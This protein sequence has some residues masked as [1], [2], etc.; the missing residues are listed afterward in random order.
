MCP[1][2]LVASKL[3]LHQCDVV[4]KALPSYLCLFHIDAV[5]LVFR[6]CVTTNE[7]KKEK[8]HKETSREVHATSD[9]FEVEYNYEFLE[10][11]YNYKFLEDE[12]R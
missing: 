7:S 10:D 5:E 1:S 3:C 6:R 12:D 4:S 9:N 11:Q 2:D 8:D